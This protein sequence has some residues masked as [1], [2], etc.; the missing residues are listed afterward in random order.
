MHWSPPRRW[1][2]NEEGLVALA[3]LLHA[4]DTID[5]EIAMLI[6]QTPTPGHVGQIVS[7]TIFDIELA[8]S[9]ADPGF[10]GASAP[11]HSRAG[12]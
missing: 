3:R 7:A 6:G 5:G 9:W 2:T 8:A 12:R 1:C 11:V 10:D 4:R